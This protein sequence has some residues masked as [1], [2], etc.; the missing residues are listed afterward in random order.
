MPNSLQFMSSFQLGNPLCELIAG[1]PFEMTADLF[2]FGYIAS[3]VIF[4]T[5][6]ITVV[7]YYVKAEQ[8]KFSILRE[9]LRASLF[10]AMVD[11]LKKKKKCGGLPSS[12]DGYSFYDNLYVRIVQVLSTV[13]STTETKG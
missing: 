10:F 6:H 11:L 3:I 1:F 4:L 9:T 12:G 13:F 5:C 2:A 7:L 8:R